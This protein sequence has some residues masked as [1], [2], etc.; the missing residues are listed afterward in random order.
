MAITKP[1][2]CLL[3]LAVIFI[4]PQYVHSGD[5]DDIHGHLKRGRRPASEGSETSKHL[6]LAYN[7]FY[8]RQDLAGC[9]YLGHATEALRQQSGLKS[10]QVQN[11]EELLKQARHFCNEDKVSRKEATQHVRN[12][13]RV[14]HD[15]DIRPTAVAPQPPPLGE[16][17]NPAQE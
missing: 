16:A 15:H 3:I 17:R 10:E 6:N 2:L 5:E 12:A 4:A 13:I 11:I 14:I 9:L 7:S 8:H 1:K